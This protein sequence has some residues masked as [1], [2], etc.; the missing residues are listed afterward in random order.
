[1]GS[2]YLYYDL[3]LI[4]QWM[5]WRKLVKQIVMFLCVL[6]KSFAAYTGISDIISFVPT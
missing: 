5:N 1:M 3:K 6:V 4:K 2:K